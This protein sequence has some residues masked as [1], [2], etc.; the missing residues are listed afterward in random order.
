[1][2]GL[3]FKRPALRR[4]LAICVCAVATLGASAAA[5]AGHWRVRPTITGTPASS[6]VA[7]KAYSFTPAA[8][9]PS[10]LRLTFA[11]FGKPAW[12]SFNRSTG[13]LA[14]TPTAAN[15]GRFANIAISVS[16]GFARASL[17]PF[18]IKVSAPA[19][20]NAPPTI[21]GTAPMAA[22]VGTAYSF[23]PTASDTDGDALSFSV[24]NLPAWATF[25]IATG[26]VS[27]TPAAANAGSYSNIVISVSDGTSSA[28]LAPFSITVTQPA[29]AGT[30]TLTWT[31]PV[32]NTDGSALT[33]LAGYDIRYGTS[34]S[35]MSAVINVASAGATSYTVSSLTNGT[36]YFAV[37]AYTTSGE[38]SALSNSVSKSIP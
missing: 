19:P 34:P 4:E 17:A 24:Q 10:G 14:G 6:D 13:Q 23:T 22:T 36:W 38:E 1:M 5:N 26:T 8:S 11:I 28:S 31:A 20:S 15:V 27:G 37:N 18:T 9:G 2:S 16:D 30:A 21:S 7:G 12:A 25:S 33:D 3:K 29:A 35:S 32:S